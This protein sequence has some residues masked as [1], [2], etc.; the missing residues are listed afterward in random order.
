M[1]PACIIIAGV[2]IFSGISGA[3]LMTPFFILGFPLLHIPTLTTVAAIGA[4]LFLETAGFGTGVYHYYRMHLAD[5]RTTRLLLFITIPLGV[6][7][8]ILAHFAPANLL[9]IVYG[10]AMVA[11]AG[12]LLKKENR[13]NKRVANAPCPCLVCESEC[14]LKLNFN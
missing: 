10:I 6:A 12:M 14:S 3:A 8:A 7:G 13:I 1:F 5:L 11:V 9:R 2:A 4:A